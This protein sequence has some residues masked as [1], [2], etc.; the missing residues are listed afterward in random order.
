MDFTVPAKDGVKLK[1]NV[2]EDNYLDFASELKKPW[3]MKV[4]FIPIVIG[5]LGTV[6]KGLIKGLV[7]L[8]IRGRVETI[9][10]TELLRSVRILKRVMET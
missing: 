2:K 4:S 10:T 1:E 9:Q 7:D 3:N 6:S 5:A 8:E